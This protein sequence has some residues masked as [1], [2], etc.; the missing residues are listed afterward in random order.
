MPNPSPQDAA[1]RLLVLRALI[2]YAHGQPPKQVWAEIFPNWSKEEQENFFQHFKKLG[3]DIASHLR[4]AGVWDYLSPKEDRFFHCYPQDMQDLEKIN[5]VWRLESAIVL[6]WALTLC[7]EFPP[8]DKQAESNVLKN[9]A[10]SDG[11]NLVA[12][13]RLRSLQEL[14]EKRS[15]AELWHWRSRTR[16][17]IEERQPLRA[18]P[19][20]KSYDEIVRF[21][22]RAGKENGTSS[23]EII[24][25]DFAVKGKAYRDLTNDEWSEIRSITVERHFAL[26]WLCGYAPENKWD[27]TPLGT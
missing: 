19:Q 10:L 27:E 23:F 15:R 16:Q 1:R 20:F 18:P 3:Q 2:P 7:P 22:A 24:D 14:E 11:A 4:K 6:L 9:I 8:F 21:T 12:N 13:A 26:N 25:E 5:M 17:L